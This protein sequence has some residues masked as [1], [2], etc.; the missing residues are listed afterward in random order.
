[1]IDKFYV[2]RYRPFL[3]SFI[4][5]IIALSYVILG[6]KDTSLLD[7]GN[8]FWLPSTVMQSV[9]AIYAIFIAVLVLSL[10]HNHRKISSVASLIKAPFENTSYI[11]YIVLCFNGLI[12]FSLSYYNLIESKIKILLLLSLFSL[13]LSLFLMVSFSF[14]IL[15]NT[16]G[17]KTPEEI[18]INIKEDEEKLKLYIEP[19]DEEGKNA[20]YARKQIEEIYLSMSAQIDDE[21]EK[22]NSYMDSESYK[23][24]KIIES[25][26]EIFN[27]HENPFIR[28]RTAKLFGKIKVRK[29]VKF[30]IEKLEDS[31]TIVR[32]YSA[33]AL[34]E[35]KDLRAVDP[36]IQALINDV[37]KDV[38][39][40]SA[41]ALGEIK[42]LRAVDPL[43][44]ALINDVNKDVRKSS[45]EAL[46][47]IK[48]L[49]AVDPLIQALIND[50]DA[51]VKKSSAEVLGEIKDPRAVNPLIQ[52]LINDDD[53]GVKKSSAEALGE[54]K[55][56]RAVDP[57]IQALINDVNKDVRKS[58]AEALGE[59]KDP[60]AVDSLI[61]KIEDE[62]ASVIISSSTAL[63]K[64]KDPKAIGPLI[65]N[66]NNNYYDFSKSKLGQK[67]IGYKSGFDI[68]QHQKLVKK[69]I[70]M[71][72][73]T[74]LGDIGDI[75]AVD[76]L[77][78][79]LND[80]NDD[81]DVRYVSGIA[82]RSIKGEEWFR[83]YLS[84]RQD[85]KNLIINKQNEE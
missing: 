49:R 41:E 59:I 44:Q 27:T 43:I 40:S 14:R 52:A 5:L 57:L 66:L 29:S 71:F 42:D 51:G 16:A 63:G 47:E 25:Y 82:L 6:N 75:S 7:S 84:V 15:S 46:G 74:A 24:E 64:I 78:R 37:N 2:K 45:A 4:T 38:R 26:I 10:Q 1:M 61:Q 3:I 77:M 19:D 55:D 11:I 67:I 62:D 22:L 68:L 28:A 23:E 50:D 21:T 54:I 32:D 69:R 35:I 33:E 31:Y 34:G 12:L 53:A 18:L 56:P 72:L 9:S 81:D 13:I 20:Y 79:I 83:Q 85:I 80:N 70:R 39:K 30:L 65:E 48:D 17:L 73:A 36:L 60:R 8:N 76:T 58:S